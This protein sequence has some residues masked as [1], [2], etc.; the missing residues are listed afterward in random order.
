[1]LNLNK[2]KIAVFTVLAA[3]LLTVA[4]GSFFVPQAHA[5]NAF[6]SLASCDRASPTIYQGYNWGWTQNPGYFSTA[7]YNCGNATAFSTSSSGATSLFANWWLAE[8]QINAQP[9]TA[10]GYTNAVHWSQRCGQNNYKPLTAYW[11]WSSG[12]LAAHGTCGGYEF[13]QQTTGAADSNYWGYHWGWGCN[14]DGGSGNCSNSPG[15]NWMYFY[16][17]TTWARAAWDPA[18]PYSLSSAPV[19]GSLA[20]NNGILQTALPVSGNQV[21]NSWNADGGEGIGIQTASIYLDN[22]ASQITNA[23]A[24]N[25]LSCW[26][27]APA[28]ATG[29]QSY[30]ILTPCTNNVYFQPTISTGGWSDGSHNFKACAWDATNAGGGAM[31]P[32]QSGVQPNSTCT[33][34][35]TFYTDNTAPDTSTGSVPSS[36]TSSTTSGNLTFS[37]TDPLTPGMNPA[38]QRIVGGPVDLMVVQ[39]GVYGSFECNLQKNVSGT[40]TDVSAFASC[41]SPKSYSSLT[42]GDYRFRARSLDSALNANVDGT[43]ATSSS[44]TVDTTPPSSTITA[45]PSDPSN[46]LSARFNFVSN[47]SNSTFQCQL[48]DNTLGSATQNWTACTPIKEYTGLLDSD[49]YTFRVRATDQAGNQETAG[50]LGGNSSNTV[51]FKAAA[52]LQHRI[53]YNNNTNQNQAETPGNFTP[54]GWDTPNNP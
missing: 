4:S 48:W 52:Q 37:G 25:N 1:M 22:G 34:Y 30:N 12:Y 36:P 27:T 35:A 26:G 20:S 33:S 41:S 8:W 39:P 23:S 17:F 32:S 28:T 9:G 3:C 47:E 7:P 11:W 6:Y 42:D 19:G 49:S 16:D 18:V 10:F 43:P 45:K 40:W 44:W 24:T 15:G 2:I 14:M 53:T 51:T 5:A 46:G 29:L 50:A 31:N 13:W 21:F 38:G 54:N